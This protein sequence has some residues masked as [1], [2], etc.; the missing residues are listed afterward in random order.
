MPDFKG[1]GELRPT[2][3]ASLLGTRERVTQRQLALGRRAWRAFTGDDPRAIA[4]FLAEEDA[5]PLPFLAGALRR[6]LEEFPGADD[7]LARTDR[8]LLSL[9]AAGTT[10][11][12]AAWHALHRMESQYYIADSSY[13]RRLERLADAPHPLLRVTLGDPRWF[14]GGALALTDDG[15]ATLAGHGPARPPTPDDWIG[16]ARLADGW[17]WDREHGVVVR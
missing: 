13:L 6:L 9:V 14:E 17:R 8:Q 2:E 16:G 10:D 4:R 7:G 12:L 1:L 11:P 5:T 3:L 15:R